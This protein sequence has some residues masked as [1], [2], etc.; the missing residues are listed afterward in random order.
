MRT[1]TFSV[2][3]MRCRRC[4]RRATA[5][6]RDVDGVQAVTADAKSGL[7]TVLGTMT[8]SDIVASLRDT[9]FTAHLV[10]E[11]DRTES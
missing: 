11:E 7:L 10:A 5:L 2:D 1:L 9:T 3:G 8:S 4:V 6:V